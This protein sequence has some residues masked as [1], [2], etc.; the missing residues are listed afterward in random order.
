MKNFKFIFWAIIIGFVVLFIF[1]NQE[2]ITAKQNIR[3]NLYVTDEYRSPEIPNAVFFLVCFIAGFIISYFL[4]LSKV[5]KAKKTI[6]ELKAAG[7]SH[8]EEI[9]ALKRQVETF[10]SSSFGTEE[11]SEESDNQ[12][13]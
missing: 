12:S 1:Q 3:I 11:E 4:N 2:F 6:R 10:Q 13:A 7:V 5:F 9:S 8:L